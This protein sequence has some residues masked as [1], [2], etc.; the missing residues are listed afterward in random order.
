MDEDQFTRELRDVLLEG[1]S[2][3][4][5]DGLRT[6]VRA[7]P[8]NSA[9]R[10]GVVA[11]PRS[12]RVQQLTAA[13]AVFGLVVALVIGRSQLI[14]RPTTGVPVASVT[15]TLPQAT[16]HSTN[17]DGPLV[18][19]RTGHVLIRGADG[20]TYVST[21]PWD[22]NS[23]AKLYAFDANGNLKPGWPFSPEGVVAFGAPVTG[24]N[25]VVYVASWQFGNG[26]QTTNPAA[27][28]AIASDGSVQPGWPVPVES[29]TDPAI[30]SDGTIYVVSGSAHGQGLLAL[31]AHGGIRPGWPVMLSG[32]LACGPLNCIPPVPEVGPDGSVY[33]QISRG[34]KAPRYE[35]AAFRPDGI[36]VDGWPVDVPGEGFDVGQN[37]LLYAWGE[38]TN[39][40]NPGQAPGLAIV[41]SVFTVRNPD[42]TMHAGWPISVQ[43]PASPPVLTSDGTLFAVAGGV[44]GLVGR[45]IALDSDGTTPSG[46]P[47]EISSDVEVVPSGIAE[48]NPPRASSPFIGPNALYVPVLRTPDSGSEGLLAL[49]FDGRLVDGWPVWF[50]RTRFATLPSSAG[51][52]ARIVPAAFDE[53]GN[54]YVAITPSDGA[55]EVV[56]LGIDG[57]SR[58]ALRTSNSTAVT[59]VLVDADGRGFVTELQ[60]SLTVISFLTL[61]PS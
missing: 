53:R 50:A 33:V 55:A 18:A 30:G 56:S 26:S 29:P 19:N 24:P 13:V 49:S 2:N 28:W 25:G 38:V 58:S 54:A 40:A 61:A 60:G 35:V 17:V 10:I 36:P 22:R 45:V 46:W 5:P 43:G 4:V 23:H 31:D 7:V 14:S 9:R 8:D 15:D 21:A 41:S 59:G 6:R 48:G 47:F 27:I 16:A 39:G 11:F 3:D 12:T 34:P 52:A 20:T 51:D 1:S 37:G 32:E 44:D 42:G 57:N